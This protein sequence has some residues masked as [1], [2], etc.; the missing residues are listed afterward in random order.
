MKGHSA[1]PKK[2]TELS[3]WQPLLAMLSHITTGTPA[4]WTG[5][6]SCTQAPSSGAGG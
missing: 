2:E 1:A 3:D 5:H 4:L 6:A